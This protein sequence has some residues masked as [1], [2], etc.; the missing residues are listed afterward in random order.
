VSGLSP[1][2]PATSFKVRGQSLRVDL[3]TPAVGH[4]KGAV[5]IPRFGAAAEQL[6]YLD[7]LLE[8][9]QAAAI[10][11]GGGVVVQVPQPARFALHKLLVARS[12]P[13]AFQT[14]SDKDLRQA[15]FLIEVLGED[16]PGDLALALEALRARGRNWNKSFDEGLALL[17]RRAPEVANRLRALELGN[18]S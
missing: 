2:K 5:F 3:L 12:R 9:P 10:I 16:R 8:E 13:P 18:A 7:Y 14:K 17:G 4:A 15:A 6:R 1:K 11:N